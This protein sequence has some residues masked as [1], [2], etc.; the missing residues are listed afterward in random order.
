MNDSMIRDISLAKEG[1][2]RIRWVGKFMPALNAL[3]RDFINNQALKG[4]TIVMSIHLEAKNGI[5]GTYAAV[6][7]RGCHR[8]RK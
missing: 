2:Q 5:F 3:K 4:K 6:C 1:L 7:G 8:D